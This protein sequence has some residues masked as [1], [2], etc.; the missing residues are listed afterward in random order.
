MRVE[1]SHPARDDLNDLV[2]YISRDSVR[3]ANNFAEKI[4]MA[5]R[6]LNQFPESGRI[7]PEDESQQTREII[8][9]GYRVMYAIE[10]DHVLV[11][12]V[13]HGSRDLGNRDNQ[14]WADDATE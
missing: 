9:Q 14:P 12:A 1:W 3:Y 5:T 13:M 6:R 4:L 11:L 8:V 10:S 2:R 7:V